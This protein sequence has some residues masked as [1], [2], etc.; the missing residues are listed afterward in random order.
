MAASALPE[1]VERFCRE[2][3]VDRE[4]FE[5]GAP[6]WRFARVVPFASQ[7]A[8]MSRG[9]V[10]ET[11][12]EALEPC[13]GVGGRK[14]RRAGD[15]RVDWLPWLPWMVRIPSE[16]SIRPCP[17][18]SQGALAGIDASSAAACYALDPQPGEAVLDLC[19]APGAKFCLLADLMSRRG[20]L[21]GVDASRSRILTARSLANQL[22]VLRRGEH[23]PGFR[24]ALVCADGASLEVTPDDVGVIPEPLP[25]GRE[26][27]E[28]VSARRSHLASRCSVVADSLQSAGIKVPPSR[29]IVRESTLPVKEI[30]VGDGAAAASSKGWDRI[31]VDAPCTHDGSLRHI[32]KHL[33][34]E[35]GWEHVLATMDLSSEGVAA[36]ASLQA[37]L[38]AHAFSLLRP[39][40]TLVYATCSLTR[41]Q[42]ETVLEAFL[43]KWADASIDP[44]LGEGWPVVPG[45]IPGTVRFHPLRNRETSGL[46]LARIRKEADE[47][48]TSQV[49]G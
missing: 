24:A 10:L 2:C 27:F 18:V 42:N 5:T 16:V 35:K 43:S 17:L 21:L 15:D 23:T 45:D 46:F 25:S 38:L 33:A 36:A 47:K 7:W 19:A 32:Q 11:V 14:R 1:A 44:I 26:L 29:L 3:G 49:T 41:V 4:V 37:K 30:A 20:V 12:R 22:E 31:L 48:E 9:D 6:R 39:G 13:E 34:H 8:G 28:L 40:G